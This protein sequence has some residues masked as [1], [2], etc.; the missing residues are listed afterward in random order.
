MHPFTKVNGFSIYL[1]Y[2]KKTN[3]LTIAILV[4][5]VF[6]GIYFLWSAAN[7]SKTVLPPD[8]AEQ[9]VIVYK[10]PNCDCCELHAAYLRRHGFQVEVK[11]VNDISAVKEQYNIPSILSSCHTTVI[12]DYIAEGHIPIEAIVEM[13]EGDSG[14]SSIALPGMPSGSPG[15]PGIKTG[16]F[17]IYSFTTE[18]EI[19]EF[20]EM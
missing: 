3:K 6:V 1:K 15:M 18:G 8:V 7:T 9:T 12:G 5:L 20:M 19:D 4:L 13:I 2:M 16:P 17:T 10:S 11:N 14:I